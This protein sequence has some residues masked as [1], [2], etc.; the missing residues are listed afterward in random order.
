M[1]IATTLDDDILLH[2]LF[3][4]SA[5][6]LEPAATAVPDLEPAPPPSDRPLTPGQR[7]EWSAAWERSWREL[8]D[9][10]RRLDHCRSTGTLEGLFGR[11]GRPPLWPL[12]LGD[13]FDRDAFAAWKD[14]LART[15]RGR[16]VAGRP[17]G[18]HVE[19]LVAA[20]RRGLH[21]IVVLPYRGEYSRPVDGYALILS[22]AT[23]LSPTAFP[24]ALRDFG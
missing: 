16:A 17:E 11:I 6:A 23:Y 7:A 1:T 19:E 8:W 21:E 13:A 4:R 12:E 20:W 22:R 24:A 15:D 10:R 9:W 5:F 3:L 18:R 2:Y 14:T